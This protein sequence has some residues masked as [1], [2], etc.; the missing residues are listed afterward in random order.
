MIVVQCRVAHSSNTAHA[1]AFYAL[2]RAEEIVTRSG[3]AP[4]RVF[5]LPRVRCERDLRPKRA[6]A[7]GKTM[8]LK[9]Q[10]PPLICVALGTVCVVAYAM[11]KFISGSMVSVITVIGLLGFIIGIGVVMR[12]AQKA[13]A[14]VRAVALTFLAVVLLSYSIL[15]VVFFFFQYKIANETSTFFQP[16]PLAAATAQALITSQVEGSDLVSV[17]DTHLH[18]WL[19]RNSEKAR[20][21]VLIYFGGSGSESSKMIPYAQKLHGWLVALVNYRGFG[22]SEGTPSQAHAFAD[23]TFLYDTISKRTDVDSSRIVV[24]GYSLGTGVAVYVAEQRPVAS[25]LLV[26]PYD[27]MTLI[28]VKSL[29]IYTP[30]ASIM[31]RYFDSIS[32]APTIQNPLLC[33]FGTADSSIPP[34]LSQKLVDQWG[35]PTKVKNYPNEDH[36]LLLHD[37]SSWTDI[38]EF[39]QNIEACRGQERKSQLCA[40]GRSN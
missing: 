14:A 5:I 27:S 32:R 26:A 2:A 15:F 24:M 22:L 6:K 3:Q 31:K 10:A 20:S 30:L 35:G 9:E 16:Q 4:E 36:D 12:R 23:A 8:L 34:Q 40:D 21:P 13:K 28:G 39:L 18:G 19:V 11:S 29:G 25:T 7:T 1:R 17:D 38:A 37:N 33:L